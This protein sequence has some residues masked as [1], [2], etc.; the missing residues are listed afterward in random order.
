MHEMSITQGIIDICEQH[1]GNRRVLSLDVEI[2]EL[3]SI[4]PEAVEFCFEACSRGTLLEG[5]RLNIIRIPGRG[6][7]LDCGADTPLTA[8]FESCS[9]CGGYL[10]TIQA[11]EELRVREIEVEE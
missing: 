9:S 3:G 2:G 11:G 5:A 4:V 7:C 6:H 1:A 10:V 8:S